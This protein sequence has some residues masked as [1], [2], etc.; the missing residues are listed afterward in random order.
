MP[1]F[2]YRALEAD[3]TPRRGDLEAQ[4]SAA[5]TRLLH[6]RGLLVVQVRAAAGGGWRLRRGSRLKQQTVLNFTQQLAILLSAGQPLEQALAV[7]LKHQA[8]EGARA[9]ALLERVRERVKGGKPLSAAMAEE[10][11]QFSTLYL[12]IVRAGEASGALQDTLQQLSDYL[13]RRQILRGQVVNALIYPAFLVVGVLGALT[14]LVGYVVPQFVPIFQDLGVPLPLITEAILTAGLFLGEHWPWLLGLLA[15]AASGW[16]AYWRAPARKLRLHRRLLGWPLIGVLLKRLEAARLARTLGTLLYNGV[17]ML[18]A[19]AITREVCVNQA[20]AELVALALERVRNG[21]ALA[22]ALDDDRLLPP[23]ALQ[24]IQVGEQAGQ[25]DRVLL[26]VA[27]VFDLQ[28]RRS[29]DRLLA[30]LVPTLTLVMALLV[31]VIMLAIML[32]L[33]SLTNNL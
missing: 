32:P 21:T 17:P 11:G 16:P 12:S 2:H 28:A 10:D 7:L 19:L 31:A 33:M 1:S 25:L 24:M 23:L 15:V 14:L 3:G 26:K 6:K 18:E 20:V 22:T 8:D 13:E 30:A 27:D 9:K 5:V 4:D 29:I